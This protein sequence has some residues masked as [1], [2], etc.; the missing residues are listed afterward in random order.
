M[1]IDKYSGNSL[2]MSVFLSRLLDYICVSVGIK[3]AVIIL[4][5]KFIEYKIAAY[6]ILIR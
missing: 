2:V 5:I 1:I 6:G 4:Y 3:R